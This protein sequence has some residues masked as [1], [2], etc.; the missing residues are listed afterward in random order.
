MGLNPCVGKEERGQ[1]YLTFGELGRIYRVRL[2]CPSASHKLPCAGK[3][4][5]SLD[6]K[7][8]IGPALLA[9]TIV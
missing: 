4:L 7:P 5:L 2:S 1:L 6:N 9:K 8:P 3:I